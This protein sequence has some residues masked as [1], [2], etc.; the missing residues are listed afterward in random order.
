MFASPR[1]G[2]AG[3][4]VA[5][6]NAGDIPGGGSHHE[7]YARRLRAAEINSSFYRPHSVATYERWAASTPDDFRFAVKVP[8]EATHVRRLVDTEDVLEQFAAECAGLGEKLGPLLVQLPPSLALDAESAERFLIALLSLHDGAVAIEPRHASWMSD[9][10]EALLRSYRVA[11]VAA[12]PPRA[13][14]DAEPGGWPGLVYLRLHGSPRIYWSS[15]D[16]DR[17]RAVE[18]TLREAA[19]AGAEAWCIFDNTASGA[20]MTNALQVAG[21]V[22]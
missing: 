16:D 22:T 3:W 12:D 13:V 14:L 17:L 8:K 10:A 18:T 20:A 6:A 9:E 21:A 4:S 11:R 2:T 19:R 5:R 15:Y 7:R 1:V